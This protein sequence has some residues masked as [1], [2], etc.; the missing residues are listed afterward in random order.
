MKCLV[1]CSAG[2][3]GSNLAMDLEKT[4]TTYIIYWRQN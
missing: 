3:V 1:T 2:F 4:D